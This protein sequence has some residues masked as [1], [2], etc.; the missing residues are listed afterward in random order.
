MFA[1]NVCRD[2]LTTALWFALA[3]PATAATVTVSWNQNPEADVTNYNVYV[4]T[5]VGAYGPATP[6]GNRTNW[7]F[8]GLQE[9]VQYFFA[10]EAQS[11]GG[12]SPRAEISYFTPR[13]NAPG[14]E[15]SR[16]DFNG[17]GWFDV[18]W[19]H[20]TSGD[21][22]VWHLNGATVA[23][24]RSLATPKTS[25]EWKLSGSGDFNRDGKP[26]LVWHNQQSGQVAFWLMNGVF[27]WTSGFFAG[28]VSAQWRIASIRDVDLDG[29]PDLWW[30][31][32]ATGQIAVW[33]MN[34]VSLVRTASPSPDRVTDLNW[35]LAGTADFSGDGRP[36]ALWHN[37]ATGELVIWQ[38]IETSHIATLT[39]NPR[40]VAP[41]WKIAAIGDANLD[42]KTDIVW[43]DD[44]SGGLALW[45]MNGANLISGDFLSI[46]AVD[47]NWKIMAP[48]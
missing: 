20:R 11:P 42:G 44:A 18:L 8:V 5:N 7:T 1:R 29:N 24:A 10:V 39:P 4:R 46:P 34:G 47:V 2:L 13:T 6:I 45:R 26:D 31:N 35:K 21:L 32:Q 12:V 14:S 37:Q 15:A 43:Q 19:Q 16:S 38:M 22:A 48:K 40:Y 17:D 36:D 9:N 25:P 23:W 33:Y 28:P 41:G 27:N 30:H 3:A